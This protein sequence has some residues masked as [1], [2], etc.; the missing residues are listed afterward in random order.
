M[1]KII[2]HIAE[3]SGGVERYL[4]TLLTKLKQYPEYEHILVCSTTFNKDKF[5][6]IVKEIVV[7]D[8]MHNA[9]SVSADSKA[10]LAVRKVIKHY[11]PDIVYC[12]SSKAGAI[13]RMANFGIKNK[14]IYNAHGWA[15]NMKGAS[16]KKTKA[17]EVIERMLVPMA[18]KIVCISEYEKKSALEHK[19]HEINKASEKKLKMAIYTLSPITDEMRATLDVPDESF[20]KGA[21]PSAKVTEVMDDADILVHVEPVEKAKLENCRL[22]FSTKIVDYLYKGKCVLAVGGQNASMQYLKDNNAAIVVDDLSKLKF[23]LKQ[24][25]DNPEKITEYSSKAW[26][27]GKE[28]HDIR[29]IQDMIWCDFNSV[30][31]GKDVTYEG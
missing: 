9:I 27:C 17:Y 15:F 1:T 19:I 21:I 8:S 6:G 22:S 3:A 7:V 4:V 13:G 2:M 31:K 29:K 30:L 28:N 26:E 24:L 20:L 25:V 16:S 10:V 18:D 14:L 5:K 23:A 11:K 12:H